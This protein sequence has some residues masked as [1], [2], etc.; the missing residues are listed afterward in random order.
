M[1]RFS[2]HGYHRYVLVTNHFRN[3]GYVSVLV[4]VCP[5]IVIDV[6]LEIDSCSLPVICE[7]LQE[8]TKSTLKFSLQ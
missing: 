2:L 8:F 4:S 1:V 3:A 7:D 5:D 6:P